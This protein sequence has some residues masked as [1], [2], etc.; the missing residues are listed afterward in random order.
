M[1]GNT[2]MHLLVRYLKKQYGM[3]QKTSPYLVWPP[4]ASCR[5]TFPSHIIDQAFDCDLWNVVPLLFKGCLMMLYI[6][7]KRNTLSYTSIQSI[8]NMLNGWLVN[9][10]ANEELEHFQLPRIVYR[11]LRHGVVQYHSETWGDGGWWIA[12]RWASGSCGGISVHLNCY[13]YNAIVLA[14]HCL[15]LPISHS[16]NGALCSQRWHQLQWHLRWLMVEK[17][18][19]NY[20]ATA[21]VDIPAVSMPIAH[22]LNLRQMALCLLYDDNTSHFRAAFYCPQRKVHLCNDHAV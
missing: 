6:G 13:R 9:M 5:A 18:T 2:D 15:C 19:F 1:T 3:D 12:R 8:P 10:Q 11:S 22:S 7:E 21:L 4:L 16:H 20:L 17:L 14:V